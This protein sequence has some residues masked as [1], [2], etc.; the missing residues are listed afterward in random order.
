MAAQPCQG[1]RPQARDPNQEV[2][3]PPARPI[4][5]PRR[6]PLTVSGN[7]LIIPPL[8]PFARSPYRR[9]RTISFR[10]WSV[11]HEHPKEAAMFGRSLAGALGLA[12]MLSM[13]AYAQQTSSISG[14]VRDTS[15]AVLPGA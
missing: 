3:R 15:G 11:R 8:I 9:R 4:K 6:Y 2:R 12:V 13:P 1:W 7:R 5:I 14:V 10:W